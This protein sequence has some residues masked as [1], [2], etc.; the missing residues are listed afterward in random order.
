MGTLV[1]QKRPTIHNQRM[2]NIFAYFISP[3]WNVLLLPLCLLIAYSFLEKGASSSEKSS[4]PSQIPTAS[5]PL[6]IFLE[7]IHLFP[8]PPSVIVVRHAL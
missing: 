7:P 5:S 8:E 2:R 6:S 1:L 4:Q 3:N